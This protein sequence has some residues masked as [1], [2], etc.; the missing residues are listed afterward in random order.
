MASS[1]SRKKKDLLQ[2]ESAAGKRTHPGKLVFAN[3]KNLFGSQKMR[4]QSSMRSAG[5]GYLRI[6]DITHTAG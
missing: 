5:H 2:D 6:R 1:S 4:L 3:G